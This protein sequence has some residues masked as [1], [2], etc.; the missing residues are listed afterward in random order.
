MNRINTPK[1]S[2]IPCKEM[3]GHRFPVLVLLNVLILA[4]YSNSNHTVVIVQAGRVFVSQDKEEEQQQ[5]YQQLRE[6]STVSKRRRQQ[7]DAACT[8]YPICSALGLVNDCCPASNGTFLDCCQSP[9]PQPG[10]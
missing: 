7:Q 3:Y 6:H 4:I 2:H 9:T 5:Y 8:S 10:M 1:I